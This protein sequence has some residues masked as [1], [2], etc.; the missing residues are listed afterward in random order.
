MHNF[1]KH[2]RASS[3]A[4]MDGF[5]GGAPGRNQRRD[6]WPGQSTNTNFR[7]RATSIDNFK[8]PEGFHPTSR[9]QANLGAPTPPPDAPKPPIGD[10]KKQPSLLN[11]TL[12]GG[13]LHEKSG[14]KQKKHAKTR[15]QKI[16]TW[17][18]RG[19]LVFGALILLVGGFLFMKGYLSLNKVFKGGGSAA[20]LSDNVSPDL[21]RGEGDGR[22]NVLLLGKGGEGHD[23]ADLTDTIIVASVDP[24]NKTAALVSLPR[25][26]WVTVPGQGSSKINAVYANAKNKA[27]RSDPKDTA[28]AEAAG[29]SALKETVAGVLAIPIHYYAMIDFAGFKQAVD[30]VGGVDINVPQE[31]AVSEHLWDSTTRKPYYLNVPAGQQHFDSTKALYFARSRKT[32]TR[33]DFDRAERQRLFIAALSQ[34]VLSAGTY[35]NP[36]KIS[37]LLDAFGSH[38]STDFSVGDAVRLMQIAKD[39]PGDAI[40]SV[41]LADPP[42]V[43][44]QTGMINGQSTVFPTAG[45]GNFSAI[46]EYIR[47]KL[48]D[49]YILKEAAN[50]H[51]LNGTATSGLAKTKADELKS[52]GYNVTVVGD[53]P[54]KTYTK[55]ILVDLT[56]N[57]PYTK[58]YLEKRFGVSAV[59]D[60]PD[61]AIQATGADFVIILG[62]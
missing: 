13:S 32:S 29:I 17:S 4:S 58:N 57:K 12:P 6:V 52:Y 16:R 50:V 25:D 45:V 26:F 14:R 46:Q 31:L 30:I 34:K 8:R 3:S 54:T 10:A 53:A 1:R 51:V 33:G 7:S 24:V 21:L 27:L 47:L 43:L 56:G 28:K 20:A 55:T 9:N 44:V 61:P 42:H 60:L 41:G 40:V 38:V 22:V 18:F 48:Q 11:M 37:Q 5:I 19:A 36:V 15:W 2:P 23:G 62:Q 35:T 39:I 59:R 49:G